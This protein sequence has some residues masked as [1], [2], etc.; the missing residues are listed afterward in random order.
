MIKT[1]RTI[2]TDPPNIPA[3]HSISHEPGGTDEIRQILNCRIYKPS[4]QVTEAS[5]TTEYST[6]STTYVL[7]KTFTITDRKVRRVRFDA[8]VGA[9]ASWYVKITFYDGTTEYL[10]QEL[11]GTNTT[12]ATFYTRFFSCPTGTIRVY[13]RTTVETSAA[14]IKNIYVYTYP[15]YYTLTRSTNENII[16]MIGKANNYHYAFYESADVVILFTTVTADTIVLQFTGTN[17]MFL[18]TST[19]M[20]V[21]FSGVV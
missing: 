20:F 17:I 14:L 13:L 4:V 11:S 9:E 16:T 8:R 3:P 6:F 10:V 5:D 21:L 15:S 2:K 7:V 1:D 12:Y 19:D 18:S